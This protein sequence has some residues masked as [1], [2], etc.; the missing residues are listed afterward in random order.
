M[1]CRRPWALPLVPFYW[2]GV[3]AKNVLYDRGWL[4]A[5]N[6]QRPVVSVGS[7]SA[8]GAG[9]TPV[10]LMLAELL[11]RHGIAADVLSRGYGRGS[12]AVEEVD[13]AGEAARFG[14]EPLE[15]ARRGAKVF[16]GADRFAAGTFAESQQAAAAHLLDDGFQHRG[17]D[18]DLD[19]VLLTLED[20]QDMLL[21]AGDLRE[22][23]RALRR[24]DV[25]VVR[26]GESHA[27]AAVDIAG[28]RAEIWKIRR[29]LELPK[30]RPRRPFVFCGIARPQGFLAM[31]PQ[32]AGTKLFPD[33]HAYRE[34][35]FAMLAEAARHVGADGFITTA[36]DAVKISAEARQML[37]TVGPLVVAELR[38]AL[39]N[40]E[41]VVER[42]KRICSAGAS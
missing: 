3:S 35:D 15:M 1:S 23:L 18:R 42:L 22:P 2:V 16:V 28:M 38:V 17:L 8:G 4:K 25:V 41:R 11:A 33:H 19:V 32:P 36:K 37:E 30:E 39:A 26:E 10:V 21:P 20:V 31:L 40:E 24:A 13:P 9:K 7:L 5:R 27:L 6:L 29:Y 34:D 12:G 14:D